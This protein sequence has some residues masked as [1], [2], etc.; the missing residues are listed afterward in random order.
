M[1]SLTAAIGKQPVWLKLTC[2]LAIAVSVGVM[3]YITGD[4]SLILFY[5]IPVALAIWFIGR[6]A[7]LFLSLLCGA[8]LLMTCLLQTPPGVPLLGLRSWNALMEALFLL[9]TG[10]LLHALKSELDL[11]SKKSI[12]LEAANREL[13]AFNYSV[14]HDLGKPITI[15]NGYCQVIREMCGSDLNGPCRGYLGEIYK[16]SLRMDDLITALLNFSRLS[17]GELHRQRVDLS[18]MAQMVAV[19]LKQSGVGRQTTITVTEGMT[20]Y[21][22]KQLLRVVLENL[23][24]N[25]WKYTAKRDET[26]I[27]VGTQVLNGQPAYFVRDNG[28][29]FDVINAE[30]MFIPFHRL[31]GSDEYRGHGIGL[32]TVERIIR[33]HGGKVWAEGESGKGATIY[34]TL[35][36]G[37]PL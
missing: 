32:A 8:E 37:S 24:G 1:S 16:C 34:F 28:I 15:I 23:L 31:H 26:V 35:G 21:G 14:S 3:D 13:E 33:R 11:V 29:G 36:G 27:E 6:K 9:F 10:Y 2:C 18:G 12:E 5:V 22:D 19:E 25:A 17:H 30:K 20:V 4:F 7:G